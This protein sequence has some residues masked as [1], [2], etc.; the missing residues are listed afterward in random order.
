MRRGV[1]HL[2]SAHLGSATGV[3][4]CSQCPHRR[5]WN[6]TPQSRLR[7]QEQA[8]QVIFSNL[9]YQTINKWAQNISIFLL[10]LGLAFNWKDGLPQAH[11]M[12]FLPEIGLSRQ[13]GS[14]NLHRF[15]SRK[16]VSWVTCLSSF[17]IPAVLPRSHKWHPQ[18]HW[19]ALACWTPSSQ[20]GRSC[21][22]TTQLCQRCCTA[23]HLHLCSC[24]LDKLSWGGHGDICPACTLLLEPVCDIGGDSAS[25]LASG[26][27][28]PRGVNCQYP[29]SYVLYRYAN[30]RLEFGLKA[31]LNPAEL[32][33]TVS[34]EK[35]HHSLGCPAVSPCLLRVKH[36]MPGEEGQSFPVHP[37]SLN[38]CS[39]GE[40]HR[41]PQVYMF[42]QLNVITTNPFLSLCL[43]SFVFSF[44]LS[45]WHSSLFWFF[46][47]IF[48]FIQY[49]TYSVLLSLLACSVFLQISCIGKLIL[50]LI[51]EFIYVLIV[52]VPG[53]NLFD[54]AD[55]LVTA[56]T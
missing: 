24:W 38:F 1:P 19:E 21:C 3:A 27:H 26:G 52:E 4:C 34:R 22:C 37:F 45:S 20:P 8:V 47:P 42:G 30:L 51:I 35:L 46:F 14:L 18:S 36:V 25:P 6:P 32:I 16:V 13:S 50:M 2:H 44:D 33:I 49:F 53:V 11:D 28:L 43:V 9:I 29:W 7:S 23:T 10:Q 12:G 54:N 39:V 48:V 55:L 41:L 15:D 40:F 31:Q 5:Q 17:C 56:N